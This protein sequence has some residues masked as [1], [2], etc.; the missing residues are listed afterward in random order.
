MMKK[1][2]TNLKERI[3]HEIF[4][5]IIITVAKGHHGSIGAVLHL[6][7]AKIQ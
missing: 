6:R 4:L 5:K 3:C 1:T 7:G 2:L